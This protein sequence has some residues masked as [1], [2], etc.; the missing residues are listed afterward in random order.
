MGMDL[1]ELVGKSPQEWPKQLVVNSQQLLASKGL[2]A[3][4]LQGEIMGQKEKMTKLTK[5]E[6]K[7]QKCKAKFE[8][9]QEQLEFD[10]ILAAETQC[11]KTKEHIVEEMGL[12]VLS[13]SLP[14]AAEVS[15]MLWRSAALRHATVIEHTILGGTAE[16]RSFLGEVVLEALRGTLIAEAFAGSPLDDLIAMLSEHMLEFRM[17]DNSRISLP[18]Y[19]YNSGAEFASL[20]SDP[21]RYNAGQA[22][23]VHDLVIKF[24]LGADFAEG[25]SDQVTYAS[26]REELMQ[27]LTVSAGKVTGNVAPHAYGILEAKEVEVSLIS[28]KTVSLQTLEDESVESLRERAQRAL[29]AGKGRL[30]DST[31]SVLDGGVPLKKARLQYVEPLTLQVRRVVICSR[32]R[33]FAALLGDGSVVTWGCLSS[34]GCSGAVQDQLKNVQHIQATELA[35]AAIRGDGSVVIWGGSGCGGCIFSG[36]RDQL[37]TVQ[38]IQATRSAFAA[39]LGDGSV[40]TWGD[41]MCGGDSSAVRDQLTNV[42]QIQATCMAFAAIRGD[43]SVVTWGGPASG[44]DSGAVR[45]QLKKNVQHIQATERAF[46]AIR[47]DGSVVTWGNAGC[48]ADSRG[49]QDQLKNVQRIQATGSAFAAILRDGSVVTWG[50]VK[51]GGDSRGVRDR[52]RNVQ[53]IQATSYAFAAIRGDGSVVTWGGPVSGGDS[54]AVQDQLKKNVQQCQATERAFAAIRGDGSVVIWGNAGYGGDSWAVQDQLKNVQHIQATRS[55][56]AAIL[57]DGSVVTWGDAM[58]G[59]DSS[60]VRGQ[61]TNVQQIQ[62]TERAF[63]AILGDG[64]VVTWGDVMYGGDMCD[65]FSAFHGMKPD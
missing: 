23:L 27:F 30:L 19:L 31:G 12:Q 43:G 8:E 50:Y 11:E 26:S 54:G 16:E 4:F 45:D 25:S 40:V 64:S 3:E 1:E 47:G 28:G 20:S 44:G 29:G 35:F 56:F 65:A 36:V 21:A 15:P 39:I 22:T 51:C 62:A 55:A 53:Q 63:A 41:A 48:G 57:G 17:F 18:N 33:A 32:S 24:I 49:V 59:G 5:Q 2:V 37:T 6:A 10:R 9:E 13:A 7:L 58:Y 34:G 38:Q 61:L 46:A 52:L 14:C 42:Q 60:A